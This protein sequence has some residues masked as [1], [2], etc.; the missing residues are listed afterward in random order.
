MTEI[1]FNKNAFL[2]TLEAMLTKFELASNSFTLESPAS[3]DQFILTAIRKDGP[4]VKAFGPC[5]VRG[6]PISI[7]FDGPELQE[8]IAK[9]HKGSNAENVTLIVGDGLWV[10]EP[11]PTYTVTL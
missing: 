4:E 10:K 9:T 2:A 8:S 1:T 6:E 11:L 5:E 7:R 3:G